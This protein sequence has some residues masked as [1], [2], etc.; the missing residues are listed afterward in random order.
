[1]HLVTFVIRK[2]LYI[3]FAYVPVFA[4]C[5]VTFIKISMISFYISVTTGKCV[6]VGVTSDVMPFCVS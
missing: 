6:C 2:R 3:Y 5:G 4:C 1:M